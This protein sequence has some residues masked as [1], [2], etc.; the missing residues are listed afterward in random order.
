MKRLHATMRPRGSQLAVGC[1]L[2][3]STACLGCGAPVSDTIQIDG[4]STVSPLSRAVAE[5]FGAERRDVQVAVAESGTGGGFSR[6]AMGEIDVSGASRP[7]TDDEKANCAA[8]GI[9]Y[10]ELHVATDGLAVVVNPEADWIDYLTID[11]LKRIWQADSPAK[12]WAEVREGWPDEA[13]KLFGP[14]SQSGTYDYFH[15]AVLGKTN[16][17]RSDAAL[18]VS[19]DDNALVIG[20]AGEK[21]GLGYFGFAYYAENQDTLKLVPIDGG[22]GAVAPSEETVKNNRYPLSRPLFIYVNQSSLQRDAVAAFVEFYLE[23]AAELASLVNYVS[24]DA[25]VATEQRRRLTDALSGDPDASD[26]DAATTN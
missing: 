19:A 14:D 9:E 7:I 2:V 23:H 8:K 15:E 6:L 11:E 17:F 18:T 13:I 5:T 20:V 24:V 1:L 25:A 12:T 26:A 3:A 22:D 10:V 21:H 16:N 4:S